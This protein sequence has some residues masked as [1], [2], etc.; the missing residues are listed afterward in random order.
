MGLDQ[1][2]YAIPRKENNAV[3][4]QKM[5][6]ERPFFRWLKHPNLHGWMEELYRARGGKDE[7]NCVTLKLEL[8]DLNRLKADVLANSLPATSGFFFGES[9]PE[10]RADDLRFIELARALIQE[11]KD[12]YYDS[13][14]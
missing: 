10:D 7:F 14:W 11:G 5:A 6:D 2:A 1:Y 9:S 8:S 3:I 4:D 12:V 13:W